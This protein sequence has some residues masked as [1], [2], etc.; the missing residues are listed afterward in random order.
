MAL[1]G[2]GALTEYTGGPRG[3]G[4]SRGFV[5]V[6]EPAQGFF[7]TGSSIGA[8]NGVYGR[9]KND[10]L[11]SPHTILLAY[12]NDDKPFWTMALVTNADKAKNKSKSQFNHGS[13]Q[14]DS[15]DD[16]DEDASREW[17]FIDADGR[18]RFTHS[19]DTIVPGAGVSWTHV[20][21]GV[22]KPKKDAK[23]RSAQRSASRSSSSSSSSS[24]GEDADAS[25]CA[26]TALEVQA[27]DDEEELPWQVIAILDRQ[28]MRDMRYTQQC[29]EEAIRVAIAGEKLAKPALSNL[30]RAA[31]CWL[32]KVIAKRGIEVH[33]SPDTDAPVV[34]FKDFGE[35]VNVKELRGTWLRLQQVA[36][37]LPGFEYDNDDDDCDDEAGFWVLLETAESQARLTRV[38]EEDMPT[39]Q[40]E[41]PDDAEADIFDRPFEPRLEDQSGEGA[42]DTPE[43][44]S[45]GEPTAPDELVE[46]GVVLPP[47]ELEHAIGTE[48]MLEGLGKE[49]FNGQLATIVTRLTEDDRQGVKLKISGQKISIRVMSLR[50]IRTNEDGPLARHARILGLSLA[51]L[52]LETSEPEQQQQQQKQ[53]QQQQRQYPR[54]AAMALLGA[55]L[56]AVQRDVCDGAGGAQLDAQTAYD[57]LAAA[58]MDHAQ[59]PEDSDGA[60]AAAS[61]PRADNEAPPKSPHEALES[62]ALGTRAAA[63]AT[64]ASSTQS[65]AKVEAGIAALRQI[66]I[67][68]QSRKHRAGKQAGSSGFDNDSDSLRLRLTLVRAL[69]RCHRES[70]A[71]AEADVAKRLHPESAAATLWYGRCLLRAGLSKREEGLLALTEALSLAGSD[72]LWATQEAKRRL[73]GARQVER[74][75]RRAKDAYARGLFTEAA[76]LYG[77]AIKGADVLGDDKWS[78]AELHAQRAACHRRAR[79][80]RPA[81]ADLDVALSLFPGFKR[82]LFRR[83]VCLLEAGQIQ[84]AVRSLE[85]LMG[86]DRTWPNLLEWMVRAHALQRRQGTGDRRGFADIRGFADGW[87]EA[88]EERDI[89]TE[90]NHYTVLGVPADATEKQLKRAYRVMSLKFHPDKEGGSTRAFQFLAL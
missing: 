81:I 43:E 54:Q 64:L 12:R 13:D 39:R 79:D 17:L 57:A 70:E 56:R 47:P 24:A 90:K 44:P 76:T 85:I 37:S 82:A 23:S 36:P 42:D 58:I 28:T 50:A 18:D 68:E 62:G 45:S 9:V 41:L 1:V 88:P 74:G 10:S 71:K 16:Y 5:S 25:E 73:E 61:Q 83:G 31:G 59:T 46:H 40:A 69:L 48:V 63:A 49:S 11:W 53:R 30:E 55:A 87:A 80:F 22:A 32:F 72:G 34:S 4:R 35:Y 7:I 66:M 14:E 60:A 15:E 8:M 26:T 86:L 6:N 20:H 75:E 51:A 84:E 77:E 78:R 27:P 89:A 65:L 19:G 52:G 21:R 38:A 2:P 67:D 33:V 3:G 29:Y